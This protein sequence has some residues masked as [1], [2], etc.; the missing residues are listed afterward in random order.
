MPIS[1]RWEEIKTFYQEYISLNLVFSG[2]TFQN[3][4]QFWEFLADL[5][6]KKKYEKKNRP[7]DL[8]VR[9]QM[10]NLN[11]IFHIFR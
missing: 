6:I 4:K 5:F 11:H 3:V 8:P 1:K 7:N 9:F 10:H 2:M